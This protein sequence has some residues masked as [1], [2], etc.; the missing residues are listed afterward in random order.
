MIRE[1]ESEE[2]DPFLSPGYDRGEI[3]VEDDGEDS[4]GKSGVGEVIHR[5]PKNLS[6]LN[7]DRETG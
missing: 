5:P 6:L 2:F 7:Y 1:A 3:L 4:G